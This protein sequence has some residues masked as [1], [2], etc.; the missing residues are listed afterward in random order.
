MKSRFSLLYF[1]LHCCLGICKT[2]AWKHTVRTQ[3]DSPHKY[4]K[5]ATKLHFGIGS[6][7]SSLLGAPTSMYSRQEHKM[8]IVCK[9]DAKVVEFQIKF[10]RTCT[11]HANTSLQE[12]TQITLTRQGINFLLSQILFC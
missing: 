7:V 8:F 6:F 11:E 10:L 5:P 9:Q 3:V 12:V 2:K 4:I 1:Y